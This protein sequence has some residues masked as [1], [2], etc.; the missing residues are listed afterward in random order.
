MTEAKD[1]A[2]PAVDR[3]NRSG[4]WPRTLYTAAR[5]LVGGG[6]VILGLFMAGMNATA[7]QA[8]WNVSVFSGMA[9][10]GGIVMIAQARRQPRTSRAGWIAGTAVGAAGLLAS[11]MTPMQQK[12]CDAVWIVSLGLPL[13]WTTGYG[14][15]WSQAVGA[16][17]R[18]AWDPVSA[19][20][21]AIFWAYAGLIVAV[22]MGLF[23]GRSEV[24]RVG[25]V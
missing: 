5:A 4:P 25:A 11:L 8:E 9:I 23:R 2:D 12:C 15:T 10:M 7:Y 13:P 21:N 3:R 24:D 16:A 1:D 22:A 17:W 14:D 19:I 20:S 18:G 6:S